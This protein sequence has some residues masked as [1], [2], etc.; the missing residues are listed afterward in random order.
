MREKQQIAIII[1]CRNEARHI[2]ACL[3]SILGS[4]Y[5]HSN[6]QIVVSDGES[7]DETAEIVAR[8]AQQYNFISLI[9][10]PLRTVPNALNL[11]IAATSAPII[12]RF[13][14]HSTME[15]GYIDYG[16]EVLA[17]QPQVGN[18]GGLFI[19]QYEN[20]TARCIAAAMQSSFGVGNAHF[21][22]AARDG[23]VDTVPYG[24]FRREVFAKTG[25]FDIQL[26]R[27]QDDEFNYRLQ[28]AGYKIWLDR[29]IKVNYMVR[30]SFAKLSKQYFQ[31]GYWKVFVNRK[32]GVV[33]SVRQLIPMLFIAF[34]LLGLLSSLLIN[35][36]LYIY[37]FILLIYLTTSFLAALQANKWQMSLDVFT[38]Q[39]VFTTLH[40]SYGLGYWQ[41]IIDFLLLRK[42]TADSRN[43]QMSH[44]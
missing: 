33:T 36:L 15:K 31:Y 29:R 3:D 5:P 26:T 43:E 42:K 40:I 32:H 8:H 16:L 30:G 44:S 28:Q 23:Y 37:I 11:A 27:N 34:L 22:T 18:V 19:N 38:I 20:D 14:A 13:D 25:G 41:G 4:G 35:K 9:I 12:V 17:A 7:T 24:I 10:N 2:T 1:P 39:R 6:M 21:R